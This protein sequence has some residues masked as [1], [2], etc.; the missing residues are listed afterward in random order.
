MVLPVPGPRKSLT[1]RDIDCEGFI[2]DDGLLDIEGSLKDV[3][4][5]SLDNGWRNVPAGEPVH[6]MR[7][8]VTMDA[9]CVIR[10]IV[11]AIEH[12]PYPLCQEALPNLQ[13]LVGLVIGPGFNRRMH[14][15]IGHTA[16]CTH[17]VTMM[18]AMANQAI[19]TLAA[20]R[21]DAGG[22]NPFDAFRSRGAGKPPLVDTC[23]AYAAD[24]PVVKILFPDFDPAR[25]GDDR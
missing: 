1:R 9:G 21:K 10:E 23:V 4:A 8:R 14:D 19:Q 18:Q 6:L 16:G 20:S 3:R 5:F 17:L 11:A 22:E 7:L 2:R 13:R 24:S 12:A 25:A 15:L